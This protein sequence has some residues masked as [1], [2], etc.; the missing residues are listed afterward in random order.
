VKEL[1]QVVTDSGKDLS[2]YTSETFGRGSNRLAGVVRH[3]NDDDPALV[4][5]IAGASL[6]TTLFGILV[7]LG[8]LAILIVCWM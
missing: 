3:R 7:G 8:L 6:A 5:A 4:A 2:R 1:D